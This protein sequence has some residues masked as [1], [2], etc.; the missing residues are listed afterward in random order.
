WAIGR[1]SGQLGIVVAGTVALTAAF[2]SG[3]LGGRSLWGSPGPVRLYFV[4]WPFF[5]WWTVALL[6]LLLAPFALGAGALFQLPRNAILTGTLAAAVLGAAVAL[7]QRPRVTSHDVV[8]AGLPQAFEGY[9]IAQI[10]DLHCG[11]FASEKR[12]N[13][14]VAVVNGLGAD[15]VVV[16]GDLIASG[17]QFVPVVA[18]A[19]GKLA[20]RDGVFASMGNH[21]YFTDGEALVQALQEAGLTVLRNE[22]VEIRRQDAAIYLGGVDDTWTR[23]HDVR[24]ALARRRSGLPVVLLAHDPALF[25]EA[26]AGGV[27]LTL[28]GHTHGGQL[29]LPFLARRFNLARLMTP[30]TSGLYRSGSS[31]LYVNRGLG[32]TGPPIRLG[33]APEIAVFVL[34]RSAVIAAGGEVVRPVAVVTPARVPG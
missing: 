21:D 2:M 15:L 1:L 33:V 18:G 3:F 30:L 9:R 12:V 34:R 24:K 28:S 31:T 26:V 25:P 32:T 6:F 11:P 4:I 19:L 23:R 17:S 22:G 8:I 16:T 20:A 10:S 14:W 5:V 27:D 13:E 7:R 29:G